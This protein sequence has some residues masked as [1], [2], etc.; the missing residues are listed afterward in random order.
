M[1][2]FNYYTLNKVEDEQHFLLEC[3]NYTELRSTFYE[4]CRQENPTFDELSLEEK[5]IFI[6]NN[7]TMTND[8]VN[9]VYDVFH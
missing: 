4:K 6:M 5:F 9:F 8:C 7:D 3:L 2:Y 1:L